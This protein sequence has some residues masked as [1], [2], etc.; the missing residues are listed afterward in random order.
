MHPDEATDAIVDY[1]VE[2]Q[3]NFVL[4]P[5][6]VF[7]EKFPDRRYQT[8]DGGEK[9]VETFDE[10]VLYLLQKNS[11]NQRAQLPYMGPNLVIFNQPAEKFA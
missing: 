9:K 6:C 10:L 1:A 3:K 2:N 8:L 5:C 7:P 11:I 4:L